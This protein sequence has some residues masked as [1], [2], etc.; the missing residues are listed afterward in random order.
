MGL[1][2]HPG[3]HKEPEMTILRCSPYL[4]PLLSAFLLATYSVVEG[5]RISLHFNSQIIPNNSVLLLRDIGEDAS[6]SLQCHTT[7]MDC[8]DSVSTGVEDG[9]GEWRL[10]N[11]SALRSL[12]NTPNEVDFYQKR[13]TRSV[14]LYRRNNATSPEGLFSCAIPN[15]SGTTV[16]IIYIGLYVE[17]NGMN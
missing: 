11:G 4:L 6:S 2:L 7:R 16:D 12:N 1:Y 17:G 3:G 10:P 9:V 8:C 14:N 15:Q 13:K 5:Q